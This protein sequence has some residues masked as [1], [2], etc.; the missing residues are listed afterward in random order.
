MQRLGYPRI[1]IV[2]FHYLADARKREMHAIQALPTRRDVREERYA[3]GRGGRRIVIKC[4]LPLG[5][6]N[7]HDKIMQ[8]VADVEQGVTVLSDQIARMSGGVAFDVDG[9]DKTRQELGVGFEGQHLRLDRLHQP[10][11]MG[12]AELLGVGRAHAAQP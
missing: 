2:L 11:R 3:S 9:F 6:A 10:V 8:H 7:R 4:V 12:N 1:P 5:L